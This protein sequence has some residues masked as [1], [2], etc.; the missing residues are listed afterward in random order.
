MDEREGHPDHWFRRTAKGYWLD[1]R[2]AAAE[3]VGADAEDVVFVSNATTGILF[4]R[5]LLFSVFTQTWNM[6]EILFVGK[7]HDR[8]ENAGSCENK[9]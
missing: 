8:I 3:F 5:D 6:T 4:S 7:I 9:H 1:A 2:K